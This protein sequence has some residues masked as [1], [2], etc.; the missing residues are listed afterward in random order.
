MQTVCTAA[1]PSRRGRA[2]NAVST[3]PAT[4][5]PSGTPR[6]QSVPPAAIAFAR[7]AGGI[8]S[9][10]IEWIEG[11]QIPFAMPLARTATKSTEAPTSSGSTQSGIAWNGT[12]SAMRRRPGTRSAR[13]R[14]ER[15]LP[16][17]A[18]APNAA[19]SAPATFASAPKRSTVSTGTA[20]KNACQPAS[21]TMKSGIQTRSSGSRTRKRSPAK[22]PRDSSSSGIGARAGT[23]RATSRNETTYVAASTTRTFA[24]P[25]SVVVRIAPWKSA[26]ALLTVASSSPSISGTI[27]FCEV[28]Y[29]APKTPRSS[30][31][32]TS[33]G[34]VRW[35]LQCSTGTSNI[36]GARTASDSSIV[37]RAPSRWISVPEGSP[38][39]AKPSSSAAITSVIRAGEPVVVSTNQGSASQ[40]ICVPVIEITSAPRSARSGP[41]RR[42]SARL[43][44]DASGAADADIAA[45]RRRANLDEWALAVRRRVADLELR[46]RLAAHRARVDPELRALLDANRDVARGGLE[47]DLTLADRA[48]LLVAGGRLH[49]QRGARLPD[50]DVARRGADLARPVHVLELDVPGGGVDGDTAL[51]P[52]HPDVAARRLDLGVALDL[53]ERDVAGGRLD[54][55][56]AEYASAFDVRGRRRDLDLGPRGRCHAQAHFALSAE[57][58]A[59]TLDLDDHLVTVPARAELDPCLLFDLVG[60]VELDD[61]LLPLDRL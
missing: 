39:T 19:K 1:K 4:R 27:T 25:K 59:A 61:R 41:W 34:K 52:G 24:A 51:H 40:V 13:K 54:F 38:A 20:A 18:P 11:L 8:R 43:I 46:A 36:R 31:R 23:K 7:I 33:G 42:S 15:T 56:P 37:R 49:L 47:G 57:E 30:A 58:A 17:T 53:I 50:G 3:G 16:Q 35:P 32:S 6:A 45:H 44:R 29:G 2:P 5:R 10:K 26:L 21:P 22:T 12:D 55:D 48:D 60:C 14:N 28:K 9:V